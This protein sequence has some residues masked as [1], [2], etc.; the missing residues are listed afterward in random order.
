MTITI[1]NINTPSSTLGNSSTVGN[2]D[3]LFAPNAVAIIGA[4][5]DTRKYGNWIAVQALKG[6][7]PVHLIN[8]TRA[9]VLG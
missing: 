6:D 5:D 1:G 7:R 2:L 3:A 9:I 8:R 4:S